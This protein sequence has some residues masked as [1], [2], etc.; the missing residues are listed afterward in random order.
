MTPEIAVQAGRAIV[1]HLRKQKNVERPKIVIGRDTRISGPMLA[2]AVMAGI[3]SMGGDVLDA[4]IMPTPGVAYLTKSQGAHAGIVISASHNPFQD[5]GIKFFNEDGYKLSDAEE[6]VL[7][8]LILGDNLHKLVESIQQTGRIQTL[9]EGAQQYTR[10][11]QKTFNLSSD[12]KMVK[13]ILD[14]SNGATSHMAT[15]LFES[16]GFSV[17]AL[18]NQPNGKNINDD[19]GSQHPEKMAAA[20]V[21]YQ[22]DLGLAFD[23]DGD[24]MIAVDERGQ[25][26]TG[27]QVI[28][29][30]ALFLNKHKQLTNRTVVSTVMSNIG[31]GLALQQAGIQHVMSGVGDRYVME[32]M[33]SKG[34]NL[35]GEDSGHII[36]LDHHTTGDGMLA[37]LQLTQV[38][39]ESGKPLSELAKFMTVFPQMLVNVDVSSKPDLS[40]IPEVQDIIA[41]VESELSGKGRVLVRY[42]GTQP[43]CRV[44]VEAPTDEEAR[45]YA[46]QISNVIS[47][48]LGDQL[49]SK[50]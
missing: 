32:Q 2:S 47:E 20:V 26:L 50:E 16:L 28:A 35:G 1:Y 48:E 39:I 30:C 23:G 41:S 21:H 49:A 37:A 34:A 44:M 38:I 22:A 29:I 19:C 36:F 18:S 27:D 33:I 31:L 15:A 46:E 13:L 17:K 8:D 14:S 6:A 11:L 40:T 4:G 42:S 3:C 7:E 12:F 24:R 10:F 45:K 9:D 25:I 43:M 5:N